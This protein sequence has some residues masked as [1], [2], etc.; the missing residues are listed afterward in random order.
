MPFSPHVTRRRVVVAAILAVGW[1]AALAVYLTAADVEEDPWIA[2]MQSSR[3]YERQ[4]E[5]VGGKGALLATELDRW[6]A[7][8][9]QGR[10]LA[11]TVAVLTALVALAY[12]AWDRARD[13]PP[14][15]DG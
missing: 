8:V 9:W 6:F 11:Y 10:S 5:V 12:Y 3:E 14:G 1:I 4:V 7:G 15:A 2:D 13:A